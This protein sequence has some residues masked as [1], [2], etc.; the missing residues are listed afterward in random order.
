MSGRVNTCCKLLNLT[1]QKV[2]PLEEAHLF[3]FN[4]DRFLPGPLPVKQTKHDG[5][6]VGSLN[7]P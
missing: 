1:T 4:E 7:D 6:L 3:M 5:H 2:V